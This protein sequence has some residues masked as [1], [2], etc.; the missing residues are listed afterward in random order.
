MP[1][2]HSRSV[3]P[4][5]V[6]NSRITGKSDFIILYVMN[7]KYYHCFNLGHC[8]QIS[9]LRK[10]FC[11]S[12]KEGEELGEQPWAPHL[13]EGTKV[14]IVPVAADRHTTVGTAG[15]GT[16]SGAIWLP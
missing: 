7:Q 9:Y 8:M 14:A 11:S 5:I 10:L 3:Y 16:V 15:T 13:C 12:A 1:G 2:I 4:V 6:M